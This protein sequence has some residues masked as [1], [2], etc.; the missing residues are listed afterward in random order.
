MVGWLR[1]QPPGKLKKIHPSILY[2]S[3]V[4]RYLSNQILKFDEIEGGVGFFIMR[5][6]QFPNWSDYQICEGNKAYSSLNFMK[7][8][9]LIRQI[10][11]HSAYL[12][13]ARMDFSNFPGGW[14]QS[15]PT[16]KSHDQSEY[17]WGLS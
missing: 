10:S 4:W 7:F 8:R 3:I 1:S 17:E 6:A 16:L 9:N 5:N 2:I 11:L 15:H 14:L 13:N 12:Q